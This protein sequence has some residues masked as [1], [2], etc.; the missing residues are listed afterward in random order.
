MSDPSVETPA[1]DNEFDPTFCQAMRWLALTEMK[2]V[3][4]P[5]SW[6]FTNPISKDG[7]LGYYAPADAIIFLDGN[8][9][10]ILR[11]QNLEGKNFNLDDME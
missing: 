7:L 2:P 6:F 1:K 5:D 10:S 8:R 4:E 3:S 11:S 9:F